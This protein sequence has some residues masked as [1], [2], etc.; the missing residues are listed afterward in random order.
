MGPYIQLVNFPGRPK[1]SSTH[2]TLSSA[3]RAFSYLRLQ[4]K[5]EE[6]QTA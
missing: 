3:H 5:S 2:S 6:V 1:S 4:T